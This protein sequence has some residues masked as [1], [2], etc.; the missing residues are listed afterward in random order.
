MF[1]KNYIYLLII[2]LGFYICLIQKYHDIF[3]QKELTTY[4]SRKP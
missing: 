2:T 1:N 3:Y 4:P